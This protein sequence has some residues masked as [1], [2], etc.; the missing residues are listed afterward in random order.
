M[1]LSPG[2]RRVLTLLLV[3]AAAWY[4]A[5]TIAR[6]WSEVRRFEW[7]VDP[8]LL[9]ASV[10]AHVAV[11]AWGVWVWS[12]VL[13]HF[14][15]PPVSLGLLLR[16]WFLSNLARY[17]PG[18]VFQFVAVAQLSRA[19]GLSGAVLLAS[20]VVHTGMALLSAALLSA[21]TLVRPLLPALPALPVGVAATVLA[22]LLV[23]PRVLNAGLGV[24]R[25]LARRDVIRWN[26]SWGDGIAVLALSVVSWVFYGG[27][28]WMLLASLAEVSIRQVAMLAG[29][30]AL[31]FVVGYLAIVTPG[32]LGVREAA[33]TRLLLP[34]VPASVG[35]VLAIASRL[36]T[37]VAELIGGGLTLLLVRGEGRSAAEAPAVESESPGG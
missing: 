18:K 10:A 19:A 5:A 17:I 28:Y 25:K 7:E 27:A 36:W 34:L 33:M 15:H 29:V 11:L 12:R 30:N 9:A 14:E 37:V 16:I 26:G 8:L 13:R 22:V 35:A 1:R 23:H 24:L 6:N 32:G 2:W 21:W 31:S 3:A 20:M 4:L